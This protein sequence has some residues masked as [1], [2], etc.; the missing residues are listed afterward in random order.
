LGNAEEAGTK[1]TRR[2]VP[3]VASGKKR[4]EKKKKSQPNKD[5]CSLVGTSGAI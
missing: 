4:T 5:T 3:L 1:A 2:K